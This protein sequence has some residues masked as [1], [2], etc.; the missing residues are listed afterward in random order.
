MNVASTALPLEKQS[1]PIGLGLHLAGED[2]AAFMRTL[3]V[4]HRMAEWAEVPWPDEPKR[5]FLDT[6]YDFQQKHY[7]SHYEDASILVVTRDGARIGRLYLHATPAG[8]HIIDILLDIRERG[9]GTGSAL[10][11]W[12]Q[13]TAQ[14]MGLACV[15]LNVE[16]QNVGVRRLYE[17]HGF[18]AGDTGGAHVA[19]TWHSP[20]DATKD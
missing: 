10:L 19:M 20:S 4:D 9:A 1:L 18:V 15:S 17:R 2:D 12:T 14:S 8:L 3:Y 13:K 16:L 7:A 5:A 6:Q 11:R